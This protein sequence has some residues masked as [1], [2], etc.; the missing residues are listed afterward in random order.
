M[1]SAA[2]AWVW[3]RSLLKKL[4][5]T[6]LTW[7]KLQLRLFSAAAQINIFKVLGNYTERL[8]MWT[9]E[10]T[11]QKTLPPSVQTINNFWVSASPLMYALVSVLCMSGPC[12]KCVLPGPGCVGNQVS[13]RQPKTMETLWNQTIHGNS[14]QHMHIS[15]MKVF[16]FELYLW[17]LWWKLTCRMINMHSDTLK[18]SSHLCTLKIWFFFWKHDLWHHKWFEGGESWSMYFLGLSL[19]AL[20]WKRPKT[21]V[22]TEIIRTPGLSLLPEPWS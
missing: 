20:C 21:L 15:K 5:S 16:L 2:V 11:W 17:G 12:R 18:W 3:E 4:G 1:L 10:G 19:N 6:F 14:R 8:L 13:H 9:I 22:V 7:K